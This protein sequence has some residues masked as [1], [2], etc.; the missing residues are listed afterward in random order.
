[1]GKGMAQKSFFVIVLLILGAIFVSS[2]YSSN[3]G[4]A[5]RSIPAFT[6]TK[7]FFASPT[8]DIYNLEFS[9]IQGSIYT[10]PY[11]AHDGQNGFYYGYYHHSPP[12]PSYLVFVEAASPTSYNI[13]LD[14]FFVLSDQTS[15][16]DNTAT[17]HVIYYKAFDP[18]QQVLDFTEF[19]TSMTIFSVTYQ[20]GSTTSCFPANAIII[21]GGNTYS[22]QIDANG[23]LAIDQNA[24][25]LINGRKINLV[26]DE[27]GKK[28]IIDLGLQQYSGNGRSITSTTTPLT[29]YQGN[30]ISTLMLQ[31]ATIAG[32]PVILLQQATT[33]N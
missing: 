19:D 4:F 18:V 33:P 28:V 16:L 10:F 26:A 21:R 13:G 2:L 20:C 15:P 11:L 32:S 25:N 23:N 9:N 31:R 24:D 5:T 7:L 6:T 22:T 14:N 17:S 30:V 12:I 1:M 8:F 27:G 29:F 3:T